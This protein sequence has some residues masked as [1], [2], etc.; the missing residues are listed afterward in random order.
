VSNGYFGWDPRTAW[1]GN[2]YVTYV[3][4]GM[5]DCWWQHPGATPA[6][7]WNSL[8]YPKNSPQ[9]GLAFWQSF[10]ASKGKPVTFPEWGLVNAT[11]HMCGG[12]GGGGDD[13]Y[14]IQQMYNW[15][16]NHNVAWETYFNED[17]SDGQH[18]LQDTQFSHAASL[19]KKLFGGA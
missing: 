18:R 4:V 6:Q 13:T 3:G 2:S 17:P 9:G 15:E 12:S 1:P 8:V 5:Y 16:V 11:A 19:Y 10:A 7:R 14:F